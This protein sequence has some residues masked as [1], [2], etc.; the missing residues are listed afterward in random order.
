MKNCANNASH[1]VQLSKQ[2]TV[3]NVKTCGKR[4]KRPRP[5]PVKCRERK[6]ITGRIFQQCN[7]E[8]QEYFCS[9]GVHPSAV[10]QIENKSPCVMH[11]LVKLKEGRFVEKVIHQEQQISLY[12]VAIR[13]LTIRCTSCKSDRESSFCRGYY[14]LCLF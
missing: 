10:I 12:V 11:A 7:G 4:G 8:S 2:V 3:V 9:V 13:S 5:V 14:S 6:E 1:V